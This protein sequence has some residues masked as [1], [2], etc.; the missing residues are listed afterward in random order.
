M[1][2]KSHWSV[3][4]GIAAVATLTATQAALADNYPTRPVRVI[5]LTAPTMFTT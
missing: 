4:L 3:A 5:T 2:R 1:Q